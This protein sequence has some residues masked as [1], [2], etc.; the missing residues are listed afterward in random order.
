MK[1]CPN[2]G[3]PMMKGWCPNCHPNPQQ[4]GAYKA[5][6]TG[7][8]IQSLIWIVIGI[9]ILVVIFVAC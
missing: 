1:N 9:V 3:T 5:W 6:A 8:L 2:C 4:A 7:K